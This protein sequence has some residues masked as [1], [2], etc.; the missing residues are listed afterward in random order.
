MNIVVYSVFGIGN[1]IDKIPMLI[2]L[3]KLGH[4]IT[5]IQD[6]AGRGVLDEA[7]FVDDLYYSDRIGAIPGVFDLGFSAIP[8]NGHL[9]NK[10]NQKTLLGSFT[11]VRNWKQPD[12]LSNVKMV[13][14]YFNVD[15]NAESN[16][17]AEIPGCYYP[18]DNMPVHD[19]HTGWVGIHPGG[20]SNWPWKRISLEAWRLLIDRI[21]FEYGLKVI[22]FGKSSDFNNEI[23]GQKWDHIFK[24]DEKHISY[25][26]G[27]H[28]TLGQTA[29]HI[30][31]CKL[32][33]SCDSGLMHLAASL[34]V[35]T[36]GIFGPTS[37]IKN[38]P[39]AGKDNKFQVVK[40]LIDCHPCQHNE[41]KMK[42]CDHRSCLDPNIGLI[43]DTVEKWV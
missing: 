16:F 9:E 42:N 35:P 29:S 21:Y 19:Q 43:L 32:F 18:V 4:H 37:S 20:S 3:K 12:W 2:L 1:A 25:L 5:V 22:C 39:F 26:C 24:A 11:N 33:I 36:I 23:L 38:A 8:S 10:A 17:L 14:D 13:C 15:D 6:P 40:P 31:N 34:G 30:R 28:K 27:N 41:N 7:D